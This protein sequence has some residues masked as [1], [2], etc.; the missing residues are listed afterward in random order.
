MAFEFFPQAIPDLV[1]VKSRLFADERGSFQETYKHSEFAAGG[2]NV[3]FKQA[4]RS[5]SKAGVLRGLHYQLPPWD[6]GKLVRV[7]SGAVWDVA[8]DIRRASV[9]F[10][11]SVG[12]ELSARNQLMFWVPGGFAHGFLALSDNTELEYLCTAEYQPLSE[13]G[14]RWDDPDLAIAWP[15]T[16]LHLSERDAAQPYFRQAPVF[17]A[18]YRFTE[19]G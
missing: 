19:E 4:N 7:V 5:I 17:P 6:Q 18:T 10:G 15:R 8:V 1:L 3:I 13:T 2:I 11:N 9:S 12:V 14:I 16:V